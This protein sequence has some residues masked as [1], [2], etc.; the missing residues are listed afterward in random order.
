M[1]PAK[2]YFVYDCVNRLLHV[3]PW[4]RKSDAQEAALK[5]TGPGFST[6]AEA[7]RKGWVDVVEY[8]VKAPK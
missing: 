7:K 1:K 4:R 5:F 3:V 2:L 8:Q 6:Y